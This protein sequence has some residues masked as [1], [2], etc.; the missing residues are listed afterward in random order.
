MSQIWETFLQFID[1][2]NPVIVFIVLFLASYIENIFPPIPGDT[3][4]L[5]IAYLVGKQNL[6]FTFALFTTLSGSVF[7]FATLYF[8]GNHYGRNII[9]NKMHRF[10]SENNLEKAEKYFDTWGIWMVLTNR[11]LA[12]M[13]SLV[14]VFAG[15]SRM[16]IVS[17]IAAATFSSL[18]W[19]GGLLWLGATIGEN[20]VQIQYYLNQYNKF[21][22]ILLGI[23]ILFFIVKNMYHAQN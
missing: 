17:A 7:G 5:F 13:R 1:Q 8:L 22:T 16:N 19:N 12:G 6:S 18:V 10:V 9:F 4:L 14:A 20:W 11:F 21:V 3:I 15:L 23:I 2:A